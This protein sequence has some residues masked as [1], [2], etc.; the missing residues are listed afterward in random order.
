M[1]KIK[2]KINNK[3]E[4]RNTRQKHELLLIKSQFVR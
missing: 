3:K 4:L 2:K 1:K